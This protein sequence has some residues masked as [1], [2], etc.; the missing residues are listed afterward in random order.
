MK[1][2]TAAQKAKKISPKGDGVLPLVVLS[3]SKPREVWKLE[4]VLKRFALA[5]EAVRVE[6]PFAGEEQTPTEDR[7]ERVT[8]RFT[9]Q[10]CVGEGVATTRVAREA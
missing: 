8:E 6:C 7:I 3:R 5:A 4:S 9:A 10:W 2:L 1:C